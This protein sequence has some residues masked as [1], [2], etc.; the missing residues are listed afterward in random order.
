MHSREGLCRTFRV[1]YKECLQLVHSVQPPVC[2][3][4]HETR[5]MESKNDWLS[6]SL[7]IIETFYTQDTQHGLQK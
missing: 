4:K 5:L 7:S 3:Y 2:I 6:Y 1:V